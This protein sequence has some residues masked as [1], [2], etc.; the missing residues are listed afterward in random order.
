MADRV[1]PQ[2]LAAAVGQALPAEYLT[3][4]DGLPAR[5]TLGP[6]YDPTLDFGGRT[7]RP[8]TRE[9]LAEVIPHRRKETAF[10]HAHETA[11][12]AEFL[13]AADMAHGGE[14]SAVLVEQGFTLDRLA[15]G[16]CVGDDGNGNPL[17]VD[18]DTGGVFAYYHDGM[19][20]EQ[21]AGSLAELV[22]GSRD[23]IDNEDELGATTAEPGH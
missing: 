13:R 1:S 10:P 6:G 2:E 17:F 4:L 11:R 7:W 3:F 9:R 23:G 20:V 5:P 8:Y 15:R 12:H 14:A 19:D 22:I 16:F 21:W 18:P